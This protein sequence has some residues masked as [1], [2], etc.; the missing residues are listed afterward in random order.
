MHKK[1]ILFD[2]VAYDWSSPGVDKIVQNVLK[3]VHPRWILLLH[4]GVGNGKKNI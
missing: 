1:N 3:A 4:D 2:V